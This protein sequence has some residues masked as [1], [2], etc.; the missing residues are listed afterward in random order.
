MFSSTKI[1]EY[2]ESEVFGIFRVNL[3]AKNIVPG[4]PGTHFIHKGVKLKI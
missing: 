1:E 2:M 4:R 3:V